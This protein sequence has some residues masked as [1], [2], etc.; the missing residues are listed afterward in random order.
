MVGDCKLNVVRIV[1]G[2]ESLKDL[3]GGDDFFDFIFES[4]LVGYH[5][6]EDDD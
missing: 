6:G 3:N 2:D 5:K 4:Y 1:G